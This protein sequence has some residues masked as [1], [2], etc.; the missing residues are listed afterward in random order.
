MGV[1]SVSLISSGRFMDNAVWQVDGRRAARVLATAVMLGGLLTAVFGLS[2][3]VIGTVGLSRYEKASGRI[4]RVLSAT[5]E[6]HY[7]QLKTLRLSGV[8]LEVVGSLM[9][10][11]GIAG[12]A[13]P[14]LCRTML[15]TAAT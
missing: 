6:T 14:P 13:R 9:L 4:V 3:H 11:A 1:Y 10:A 5:D 2:L 12:I 15:G 8:I 7:G